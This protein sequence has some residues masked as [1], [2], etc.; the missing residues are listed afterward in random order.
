MPDPSTAPDV[1]A[2]YDADSGTFSY[3]VQSAGQAAII[4]PVLD[5]AAPAA[6]V[7][8]HSADALAAHV[9]E[10]GL[11]VRWILE[12]HAHADHLSAGAYLRDLLHAQL[13]I[14]RGIQQVQ[15]RFKDLFGL[16]A[17]FATDGRQFDRLVDDGDRLP[18]GDIE[19]RVLATPGHT[20]DSVTYLIGDAA[21]IGDTLFAPDGGSA[22]CDFPGGSSSRLYASIQ[23]LYALPAATRLFLCHD[24]PPAGRTA[25]AETSIGAQ[26]AGNIHVRDGVSEAEFVA[27]RDKRD[28]TLPPPRLILPAVQV[29][30]RGGRLPDPD[31]NG[32]S[33]L[34]LPVNQLGA[35]T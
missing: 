19:I 12:T 6:S 34:R 35:K 17:A 29:N 9:R 18:F 15:R 20:D 21:F 2:F 4:D 10:R 3:V 16:D 31:P 14:G 23:R 24:Y 7:A 32:I 11:T 25:I 13:V 22:R 26:K 8:T 1:R 27:L 5:F 33:Y 28:A 30:I